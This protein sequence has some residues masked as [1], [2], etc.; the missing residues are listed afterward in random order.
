MGGNAGELYFLIRPF[1]RPE[2]YQACTEFQE[3]I[4]GRGFNERVS[5]AILMVANKIGG[6]AAGAYGVDDE[7]LGFVFGLTGIR[8]GGLVHWSD[9]LAVREGYRDRG[10]GRALKAYQREVLLGRGVRRMHWT[11]DPLQS[12]NAYVNF[13]KLGIT[14]SEYVKDMYGDTGS[15]L[16]RV[17]TD[18]L[19]ATWEMDSDRV[20][21]RIS[22]QDPPEAP[23]ETGAIPQALPVRE[24]S[25]LPRPG[26]PRLALTE[27][28]IR[29][30]VPRDVDAIMAADPELAL[31]WRQATRSVFEEYMGRGYVVQELLPGGPV[32]HYLLVKA[33]EGAPEEERAGA[34]GRATDERR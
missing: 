18:R 8:E 32:S 23:E 22:G 26:E 15:P 2:E 13:R 9:M 17:G 11:F 1:S 5:A 29:L 6:L 24:G 7:L 3:E 28:T 19:I 20:V 12:R 21:R 14:S 34:L 16:H 4:W 33:E 31:L 27:P 30:P 25:P 10:L